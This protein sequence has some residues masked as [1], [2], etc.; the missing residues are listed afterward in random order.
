MSNEP[1]SQQQTISL[2]AISQNF[3]GALQ[4]QFD[5]LAYN[6]A[7]MQQ[8]AGER[9]ETL[10]RQLKLMPAPQLHQNFEQ[11]QAYARSLIFRQ[12]VNDLS[13]MAAACM[14]SCHLLCQLI[15]N[16]EAMKSNQE[17]TNKI[18][19]E[20]QSS[21]EHAPLNE[22][23]ERLEKDFEIMCGTEDAII[24]IAVAFRVLVARNGN[25]SAEDVNE[26]GELVFEFK[27]VQTINPPK[28]AENAQPEMRV[29][30]T[31]RVFREGDHIEMSNS[32]LLSLSV[33]VTAFFH[34]LFKAV[35]EYGR[36]TLGLPDAGTPPPAAQN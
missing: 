12:T 1:A 21:F 22:K 25:V 3:L 8:S 23:F 7:A 13:N 16:Q 20:T 18:L 27:T 30:D 2:Q 17:A 34:D 32:E 5:L 6:L 9:Y 11:T 24:A 14:N 4:R 10:A 26:D 33:T 19:A 31:R 29:V 28:S 15:R 35:D 36:K